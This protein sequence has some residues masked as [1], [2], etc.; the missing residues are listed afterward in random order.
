MIQFKEFIE[1]TQQA[2]KSLEIEVGKLAE[3]VTK[4]VAR[5]E[6]NFVEVETHEESIVEKHDSREKDEEKK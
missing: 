5:R 6:E 1:S 4:F 2:F 3:E